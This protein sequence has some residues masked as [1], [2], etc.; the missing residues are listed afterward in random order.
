MYQRAN[1]RKIVEVPRSSHVA[2]LSH[3]KIVADLI[4]DA[5][6]AVA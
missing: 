5:A 4:L 1:A 3:P 6:K 2:M